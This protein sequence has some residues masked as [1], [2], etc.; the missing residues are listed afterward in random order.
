M[1]NKKIPT[2]K[3]VNGDFN[4]RIDAISI[5]KTRNELLQNFLIVLD[6]GK[7]YNINRNNQ[8]VSY[9]TLQHS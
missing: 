2:N 3:M 5:S 4:E 8:N 1:I 9:G 7:T 6:E